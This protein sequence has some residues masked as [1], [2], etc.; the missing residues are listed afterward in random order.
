MLMVAEMTGNLSLLAPA[1]IAVAISTALVGDNTIYRSQLPNRASSPTHRVRFSFPLLSSLR[2]QDAMSP[3]GTVILAETKVA[4]AEDDGG[5]PPSDDAVVITERNELV[6]VLARDRLK[7]L[8]PEQRERGTARSLVEPGGLALDSQQALDIALERMALRGL[9]WA[10]VIEDHRFVGRLTVRD[11]IETYRTTLAN[12]VRRATTLPGNTSLFEVRL[13]KS[14][15]LAGQILRESHLPSET[16]VVA[17]IRDG[18]TIFPTADTRL[19]AGDAVM[20]L[21]DPMSESALRTFLGD[22]PAKQVKNL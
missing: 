14:S 5:M 18:E 1:M 10:P 21:A 2:V 13:A 22:P 12:S 15:P 7:R 16:L 3:P 8:S 11:I 4:S 19:E 9:S 6:G 17:I 20:I